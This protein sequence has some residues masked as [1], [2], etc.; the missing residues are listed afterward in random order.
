MFFR[1]EL[2]DRCGAP[3][4]CCL[5]VY[6]KEVKSKNNYGYGS[7]FG[8]PF[9]LQVPQEGLTYDQLYQL[10]L[11]RM[12]RWIKVSQ[13]ETGD[14]NSTQNQCIDN[15]R[16]ET[17]VDMETENDVPPSETNSADSGPSH[18]FAMDLVNSSGNSSI[19][20][21]KS[22]SKTITLAGTNRIDLTSISL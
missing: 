17:E 18:L 19:N 13:P 4:I 5:S 2:A 16:R 1:Y 9:I 10:I 7:M 6:L 12:K 14:S 20:K 8:V 3:G 11:N 22:S 15:V 21:L